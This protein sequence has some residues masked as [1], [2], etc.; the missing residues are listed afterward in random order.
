MLVFHRVTIDFTDDLEMLY[1]LINML[2]MEQATR[3]ASKALDNLQDRL[4]KK[5]QKA[6]VGYTAFVEV[7]YD[8]LGETEE[9]LAE[10]IEQTFLDYY[11][12]RE[13]YFNDRDADKNLGA[14]PTV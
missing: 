3:T 12:L 7:D 13:R 8:K 2:P 9:I 1:R 14:S 4:R 10:E 6:E 11:D 5:F